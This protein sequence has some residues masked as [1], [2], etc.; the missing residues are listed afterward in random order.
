MPRPKSPNKMTRMS[1]S[2]DPEIH[3]GI[4]E[5]AKVEG[6]AISE[7]VRFLAVKS[8]RDYLIKK[9]EGVQIGF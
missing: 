1:L 2:L 7:F 8:F 3:L 5:A 9:Q 4:K 6:L